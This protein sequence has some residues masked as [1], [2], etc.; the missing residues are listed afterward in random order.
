MT[1]TLNHTV[2]FLVAISF[3]CSFLAFDILFLQHANNCLPP[4]NAASVWGDEDRQRRVFLS[5]DL[6]V[7]SVSCCS[8][9]KLTA[10]P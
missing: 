6:D 5:V 10:L 3:V 2:H 1:R 8:E 4:R 9:E 7:V